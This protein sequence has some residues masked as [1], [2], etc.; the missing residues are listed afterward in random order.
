MYRYK[1]KYT[2]IPRMA[3]VTFALSHLTGLWRKN[4]PLSRI[5][6]FNIS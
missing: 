2:W 4:D 1:T 5:A 6:K 3:F